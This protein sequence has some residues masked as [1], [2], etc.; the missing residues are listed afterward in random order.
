PWRSIGRPLFLRLRGRGIP[1]SP[2]NHYRAVIKYRNR[3]RPGGVG[4][5]MVRSRYF[6]FVQIAFVALC[7]WSSAAQ[8]QEQGEDRQAPPLD[9]REYAQKVRLAEV[10]EE[11]H[12][13]QSAAR[14]YEQL[15]H[16]NPADEI[17][18]D[19]LTRCLFYLKRYDEA[20]KIVSY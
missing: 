4:C 18:F 1:G 14:V 12:D 10:Y 15:Y 19:G 13:F 3:A 8:A 16:S 17:V 5:I 2:Q 9:P 11:T 6:H 7:F 20:E